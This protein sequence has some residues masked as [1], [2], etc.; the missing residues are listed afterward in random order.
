MDKANYAEVKTLNISV[1]PSIS[2]IKKGQISVYH[3]N[4]LYKEYTDLS[5]PIDIKLTDGLWKVTTIVT[6]N[7]GLS[8]SIYKEYTINDKG[9]V[10]GPGSG[11]Y[12][13]TITYLGRTFKDYKQQ[14]FNLPFWNNGTIKDN[15]CAAISLV[16]VL[17]GY[18]DV[19]VDELAAY[20]ETGTFERIS[21]TATHYGL[22]VG[23]I[24]YYNS[25]Y[26]NKN[27]INAIRDAALKHLK[28][29]GQLIALVTNNP[30]CSQLGCDPNKFAG[31]NHFM[32]I[33]GVKKDDSLLILN[34]SEPRSEEG[35]LEEIMQYYML[36]GKKGFMFLSK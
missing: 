23:G 25:N 7:N 31:E 12:T 24:R 34:P 28:S 33:I 32:A 5:Q 26:Y 2:G 17:S 29:G 27:E 19:K 36:G 1:I 3:G 6:Q 4:N 35:T 16:N 13:R 9:Y 18:M 30:K 15:G 22:K 10:I 14:R 8:S 21:A 11:Q 20:M